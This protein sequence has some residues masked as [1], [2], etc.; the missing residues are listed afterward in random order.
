MPQ[1]GFAMAFDLPSRTS[2]R[3]N[4]DAPAAARRVAGTGVPPVPPED[5]PTA[6]RHPPQGVPWRA[7]SDAQV[8]EAV[9]ER[10]VAMRAQGGDVCGPRWTAALARGVPRN[11]VTGRPY[12]GANAWLL[13]GEAMGQ[14]HATDLWLTYAQACALGGQ[15]RRGTHGVLC[16]RFERV[17]PR[18]DGGSSAAAHA[19]RPGAAAVPP[20]AGWRCRPLWLFNVAQVDGLAAAMKED[21]EG[22]GGE[23]CKRGAVETAM[24]LVAGCNPTVRHGYDRA[25]YLPGPDEIRL[26]LPRRFASAENYCATLLHALVRWT[27]HRAR[28]GREAP[29][30]AGEDGCVFAGLVA[31]LGAS[32]LMGHCGLVGAVVEGQTDGRAAWL[33]L[34]R[35]DHRALFS[36]AR[37]ADDAVDWILARGL[38]EIGAMG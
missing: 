10:F 26:P 17:G 7:R 38:P 29:P 33:P 21:A 15:V 22:A 32:R 13:W 14:G 2:R 18:A 37:Q 35:H 34:L 20:P 12:R 23:A 3:A 25:M 27:A 11:L 24:R 9:T 5:P 4:A 6:G 30:R 8:R 36:A 19:G 16:A 31:A 28:L 1:K